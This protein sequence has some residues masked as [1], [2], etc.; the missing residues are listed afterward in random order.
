MPHVIIDKETGKKKAG[1]KK[2]AKKSTQ[3]PKADESTS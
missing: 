1:E 2:P 3:K